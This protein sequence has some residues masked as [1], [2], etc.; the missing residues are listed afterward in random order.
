MNRGDDVSSRALADV[1]EEKG[2][3]ISRRSRSA[4]LGSGPVAPAPQDAIHLQIR[5]WVAG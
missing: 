3:T 2:G 1:G 5:A 4:R